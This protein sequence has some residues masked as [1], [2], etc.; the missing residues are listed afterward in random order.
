MKNNKR[1]RILSLALSTA[2]LLS[3][4]ACGQTAGTT[5]G[6]PAG[7]T[8]AGSTTA[9]GGT[10]AEPTTEA[11]GEA[12]PIR[13]LTTGD[14]GAQPLN[15]DDR[16]MQELNK[17]FNIKLKVDIVP[18]S[19]FEKVNIEMASKNL[20][21]IVTGAFGT[22]ATQ[23]WIN[24]D[25]V[26][27]LN[28]YFEGRDAL[29]TRL[30]EVYPWSAQDGEFW[31]VPFI[32]QFKTAN[33]LIVMRQDWLD[34]L[35]LEYPETLEDFENVMLAFTNDDP[36]GNGKNDTVGYTDTKPSGNFNWAY[37][38]YGM[39]NFDYALD[40]AGK[41]IPRFETEAFKDGITFVKKLW[42]A[43]TIDKEYM[44]NDT[45]M[46]EEKF[47]QGK[48]GA[49]PAPLF[50]H[51]S[52]IENNLKKLF[53]EA[54]LAYGLP[55]K[56]ANGEFGLSPQGKSGMFT[57]ITVDCKAP[58]KAAD[59]INYILS[60]EGNNLLRWGIEGIHYTKDGDKVVLNEE[61]RAKDSFAAN[62]WAHS[63]AWGSFFWPLESA[64]LPE[65][66]P[67]RDR[68]LET[69]ELAQQAQLPNLVEVKTEAEVEYGMALDSLFDQTVINILQ[70]N[71]S[72][73]EGI[74]KLSQEWRVQ[75]GTDVL[76]DLQAAVDAKK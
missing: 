15:Q 60:E 31:G 71:V 19:N 10:T 45:N 4:A 37:A 6:A 30:E 16:V 34:N 58:D 73:D 38:A 39:K 69:I 26:I 32:T 72:V 17:M 42:D 28:D 54:S 12:V 41:V 20:P 8:A 25:L 76:A 44:L 35:G 13:W 49:M 64:Y 3:V 29:R 74:A 61:E 56:G 57:A 65:T 27:S 66:E 11:Q 21:D 48:V 7:T 5:T 70:G 24:D 9:A 62:G 55:P 68:A 47:Y 1:V 14:G 36:D 18:E 22:T 46:R 50:R 59:F 53:P 40:D 63:L 23:E 52:R 67:A 33:T 75:G 51:V 2:V 43:N